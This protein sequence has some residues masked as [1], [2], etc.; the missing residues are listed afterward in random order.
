M[1]RT[2]ILI[3]ITVVGL[4][5]SAVD[6]FYTLLLYSFYSFASP[7]ELVFGALNGFQISFF[8]GFAL[9]GMNIYQYR[10][11]V[12]L[13]GVTVFI[14]LYLTACFTS[15]AVKMEMDFRTIS[16]QVEI[17]VKLA[18]MAL[19]SAIP[20]TSLLRLRAFVTL[21]AACCGLLASY[22]GFFGLLHGAFNICGPEGNG[23]NNEYAAIVVA[24][25]PYIFYTGSW[26]KNR[27]LR[28]GIGLVFLSNILTIALTLSRGAWI[29]TAVVVPVLLL[30][31]RRK[32]L[33]VVLAVLLL[34]ITAFTLFSLKMDASGDRV[35]Y[36]SSKSYQ[37]WTSINAFFT[38][39]NT[40]EQPTDQI[41]SA[42]SRMHFWRVALVMYSAHPIDGIGFGQFERRFDEF[43]FAEGRYGHARAVHNT[44]L[45][46][47]SETGLLGTIPFGLF[48]ASCCFSL[49]R[50]K[51]LALRV[52]NDA[53]RNELLSYIR[54]VKTSALGLLTAGCFISVL[55]QEILWAI[56]TMVIALERISLLEYWK[57]AEKQWEQNLVGDEHRL[58]PDAPKIREV[59][60]GIYAAAN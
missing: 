49:Y 24:A 54:L 11:V 51:R 10:R 2:L 29:A 5:F 56:P 4:V 6:S 3:A 37:I 21:V 22:Y 28:V 13:S 25:L 33:F 34:P 57:A 45:L 40:L 55:K 20:I 18:I 47:L 44:P 19:V 26:I 60:D 38:E 35:T 7:M 16:G 31:F 52:D 50:S 48:V 53:V 9:I 27:Y 36:E 32:L 59:P 30:H 39:V 42:V 58:P 1:K 15:L 23:Q 17:V 43:D 41:S 12:P 8:I 46:I 14:L